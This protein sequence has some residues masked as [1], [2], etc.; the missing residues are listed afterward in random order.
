MKTQITYLGIELEV[1]YDPFPA[2]KGGMTDPS[3]DA[4]IDINGVTLEESDVDIMELLDPPGTSFC[5]EKIEALVIE[6]EKDY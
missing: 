3:W 5:W 2:Q 6:T 1:D 4:G